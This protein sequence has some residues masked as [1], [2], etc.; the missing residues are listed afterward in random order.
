MGY[1]QSHYIQLILVDDSLSVLPTSPHL[2]EGGRKSKCFSI[3][4][5]SNI[6]SKM[7]YL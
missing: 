3:N 2:I 7:S 4:L 1:Q 6:C 5:D